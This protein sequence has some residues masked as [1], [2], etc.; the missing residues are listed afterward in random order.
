MIEFCEEVCHKTGFTAEQLAEDESVLDGIAKSMLSYG[1]SKGE[2]VSYP[3][4]FVGKLSILVRANWSHSEQ[5]RI[6]YVTDCL[7]PMFGKFY[8][9]VG[10]HH[11]NSIH[12]VPSPSSIGEL[13]PA[14][15]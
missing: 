12:T 13:I 9:I 4:V 6:E 2:S 10:F 1:V 11:T 15:P 7:E 3:N 5:I 14:A 8:S